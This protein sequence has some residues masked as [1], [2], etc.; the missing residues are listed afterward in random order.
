MPAVD[1]YFP[2]I[3]QNS[4][5]QRKS[6][7]EVTEK[8]QSFFLSVLCAFSVFSV[9]PFLSFWIGCATFAMT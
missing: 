8:T 7:T 5:E 6:Y 9:K 3:T 4:A 2:Q 1:Y